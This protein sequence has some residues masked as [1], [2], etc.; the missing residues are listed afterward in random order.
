MKTIEVNPK[1]MI[2]PTF[3]MSHFVPLFADHVHIYI[4]IW[5]WSA[6]SGRKWL[7]WDIQLCEG[8]CWYIVQ[9]PEG[10]DDNQGGKF[11]PIWK[12]VV[13]CEVSEKRCWSEQKDL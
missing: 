4:Y 3:Q 2:F 9:E 10:L 6:K 5:T 7:F 12:C 1:I 11:L 8:V 13:M